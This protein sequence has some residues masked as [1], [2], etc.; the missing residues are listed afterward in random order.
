M[1]SKKIFLALALIA[2][3]LFLIG[4]VSATDNDT[5]NDDSSSYD[6]NI[7][8]NLEFEQSYDPYTVNKDDTF[9]V[10]LNVKNVGP[11]TYHNLTI[12]YPT[13]E[14]LNV[15][16]Y[17]SEYRD[18]SVWVIDTLYPNETNC[19]TLICT[20][21]IPNTTYEFTA[22]VGNQTVTAIDVYCQ[23]DPIVP[24]DNCTTDTSH[25]GLIKSV[26]EAKTLAKTANPILLMLFTIIFI[27][28][29]RLKY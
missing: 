7:V 16:I 26:A 4:S 14:G 24:D 17:P 15:L 13:P 5:V 12:Y 1:N 22:S 19:L 28:F 23:P 10:Y 3:S 11:E 6:D 29:I 18:Y 27:P 25:E 21:L 9:E 2:I 20:A 8:T